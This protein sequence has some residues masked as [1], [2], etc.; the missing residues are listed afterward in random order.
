MT[1]LSATELRLS[2]M[3]GCKNLPS[4]IICAEMSK[5]FNGFSTDQCSYS[6]ALDVVYLEDKTV[7]SERSH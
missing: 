6:G 3:K 4:K 2:A 5:F 1:S 7:L